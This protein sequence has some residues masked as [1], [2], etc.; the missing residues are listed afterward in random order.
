MLL[1]IPNLQ[2]GGAERQILELARR[3]PARFEPTFCIWHDEVHYRELLT[4][5][6]PRHVLG[7][8]K[9]GWK[10]LKAFEKVL[11]TERPD[12]LH[13]YRDKANFWARLAVKR[14]PVPVVITGVRSR[15]MNLRYLVAERRLSRRS[16]Q[17]VTNSVG[18]RR[19]LTRLARVNPSKIQVIHNFINVDRF[20][21]P[22]TEARAAARSQYGLTPQDIL[23]LVPGRVCIQKHHMGL[24]RA[25]AW[26]KRRG[27]LPTTLKIF[28]AGRERD[29]IYS[30]CVRR[31]TA[32]LK[33]DDQIVRL[34][35]VH[36]MTTL[37]H[38]ADFMV[39]PSL[40]EGLPNVVL[41]GS[42]CGLPAVVSHAANLDDIIVNG[43]TGI[44][45][46]TFNHIA[47]AR[48]VARMI[49]A[50]DDERRKMGLA[51]SVHVTGK[52]GPDRILAET[53]A[54]YDRLLAQKGLT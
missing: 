21:P 15:A 10:A 36:E 48:A 29:P 5:G 20:K 30:W 14:S 42:A 9:M 54:L 13:S 19:E 6:E 11:D 44:E 17:I 38:A 46:P 51:G 18:V 43:E 40:W 3:L 27:S 34:G 2:Q 53:L 23:L 52:F 1:F 41:E 28:L 22:S 35:A 26:L 24:F 33:L 32:K 4:P 49:E 50:S 47:L 31:Q 45:V 16:D 8:K 37:Y 12:I 7:V 25:L 39:L